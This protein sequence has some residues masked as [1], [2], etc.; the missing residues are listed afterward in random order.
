MDAAKAYGI[1]FR[2][3]DAEV[4]RYRSYG[5]DLEQ[6]SGEDHHLLPVP[7]VFL[8]DRNGRVRWRYSNPDYKVRPDNDALLRAARGIR[9]AEPAP[10]D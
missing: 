6:A 5:I 4:E 8:I 2:L 3:D 9:G 1:A 10:R 7:S